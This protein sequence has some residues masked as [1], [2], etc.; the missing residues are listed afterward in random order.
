MLNT[1]QNRSD[2]ALEPR[3]WRLDL[4]PSRWH[5]PLLVLAAALAVLTL[6]TLVGWAVDDRQLLGVSV[7]EKP[8]KFAV[9]GVIYAVTWAWLIGHFARLQR[10]AWWAGTVIAATLAIELVIIVGFAAV[11]VTSHFN[12][13]SPL[14]TTAWSIMATAITTLWIATFVAAVALWR[15]PGADPARQAAI[16]SGVA[17]SLL[18]MGLAFLMT[19]PNADQLNDFQGIAG[20]HAVGV[21][22]GGPGLPVLGWSTVAGDLRIPHFIGMHALQAIPLLALLLEV[23]ARRIPLLRDAAVRRGLVLTG[24]GAFLAVVG[25]VTMQALRGQSIIAPDA[26]TLSLGGAIA[27]LSLVATITVLA[28]GARRGRVPAVSESTERAPAP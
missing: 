19:G 26:L 7:W 18:G 2:H 21:A 12:V 8:F 4:P 25:L 23:G 17:I 22:D 9:S 24:A 15:N 11:G 5:R 1:A 16:R 6:V 3:D 10:A 13:S 20:A 27:A 14:A 28:S